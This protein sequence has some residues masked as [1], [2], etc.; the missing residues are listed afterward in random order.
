MSRLTDRITLPSTGIGT[1]SHLLVHRYLPSKVQIHPL[2]IY[3]QS[4]LHADEIPGLLVSHHL[5]R[6]L[7]QA[8]RLQ[9]INHEIVIIPFANPL[10]LNQYILGS[11]IGRFSMASGV[12]FN[13]DWPDLSHGLIKELKDKLLVDDPKHNVKAIRAAMKDLIKRDRS[14][15]VEVHMKRLLYEIA[16]DADIVLDLHCDNGKLLLEHS[17]TK[18]IIINMFTS[19]F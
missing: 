15:S 3:I 1:S 14:N 9:Q 5:I 7:D 6:L 13:R 4:S 10:G 8:Q 18:P 16:C 12:N 19:I 17:L 11:H 2:K